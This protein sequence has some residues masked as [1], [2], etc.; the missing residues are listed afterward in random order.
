MTAPSTP[1]PEPAGRDGGMRGRLRHWWLRRLPARARHR[2]GH[3][4]LY[5]LPTRAG[6]MLALTLALLLVG[7]INFQLNLGYALTF[8]VAGSA[9]A[10]VWAAHA[11]LRGVELTLDTAP[12]CW[13]GR[14]TALPVRLQPGARARW[15]L[16]LRAAGD[17]EETMLDAPAGPDSVAAVPW[18]PPRRGRHPAPPLRIATRYPLGVCEVW[19]WWRPQAT[20]LVY[21][22]PEPDAPPPPWAG[23]DGDAG[24]TAPPALPDAG[25][26]N[27]DVRPWRHGDPARRVLWKKAAGQPDDDPRHWWVRASV[28]DP[29]PPA[30]LDERTCGLRDPEA[31]RARLCAWVLAAERAGRPYGLRVGG[32]AVPPDLGPA[33]RRRCLEVLACH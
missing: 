21:P 23:G 22:G 27:D 33:Q 24:G 13:A 10:A 3:R 29:R 6:W 32:V 26:D 4:N 15:A 28:G 12:E 17:G 11:N 30:W 9:A 16:A 8:L 25:A 7:S 18:T 1:A 31:V 20:L 5:V 2:L 19:S 14:R